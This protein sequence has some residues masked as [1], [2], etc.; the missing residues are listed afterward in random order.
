MKLKLNAEPKDWIIF[1]IFSFLWFNVVALIILNLNQFANEGTFHGLNPIPALF[2]P[3]LPAIIVF[4][5]GSLVAI[6][7]SVKDK[8]WSRS[9]GVGI[10]FQK[11]ESSGYS[12]W[13]SDKEIKSSFGIHKVDPASEDI[14]YAGI[15][16]AND[17]RNLWVDDSE[18]H[19]LVIGS[20]GSGKSQMIVLPTISLLARKGESM[21]IT[22]PK[23]EIYK[24]DGQL[25]KDKGYK[26][27]IINLREPQRGN[28]WNPLS[29]PYELYNSGDKD[30]AVELLEDLGVNI[31]HEEKAE[32]P[33]WENTGGDFFT[34][35]SIA[36][37][38]DA[39]REEININSIYRMSVAADEKIGTHN[40]LSTYFSFKD[41]NDPA[42]VNANSTIN[43]PSETKGSILSVFRTKIKIFASRENLSQMLAIS[44]FDMRDIGHQKTAVF[45]CLQDE[46]TTYHALGTIFIKQCYETLI[47]EAS[48]TKDGK[49]PFRTNF[50]LDEFENMPPLK[51]IGTM[52]SAARSRNIRMMFII[53]DSGAL[54]KTYGK[55]TA[56]TIKGN[57]GNLVYLISTELATLEELSKLC[58]DKESKKDAK[59]ASTPLATVSDL[60]RLPRNTV[61]ILH[62]RNY[63]YKSKFTPY[64]QMNEKGLF[65]K[66]YQPLELPPAHK[67]EVEIF[68]ITDFTKKKQEEFVAKK[69]AEDRAA[70]EAAMKELE[71]NENLEK[72]K[73]HPMMA[74]QKEEPSEK[75]QVVVEQQNSNSEIEKI[76]KIIED[77]QKEAENARNEQLNSIPQTSIVNDDETP[78]VE[79]TKKETT[80]V[81]EEHT[82]I[83]ETPNNKKETDIKNVTDDEFFDDFFSDE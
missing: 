20:T 61:V 42:F 3:L 62:D 18:L 15:P 80:D 1:G 4:W 44:D 29:V 76:Q 75:P 67:T 81:K 36:L 21:I 54:E 46:K 12:R 11:K 82:N 45:L 16:V 25:L 31:V 26:I 59:T 66:H 2:S 32:D 63:P 5:I 39:K 8:F 13:V 24:A 17:G 23:Q 37:F 27:I 72:T 33:F 73:L 34:G 51:D 68:N 58:G 71:E 79:A 22:D 64:W 56:S 83:K 49:L 57:C 19:T 28:S 65:G 14:K 70:I 60:Q 48:K 10:G 40:L 38:E 35:L 47:E 30:K 43:A 74:E 7:L 6:I 52:V 77:A 78:K 9:S 41:S 55:E 53:Q 69:Q 50:I